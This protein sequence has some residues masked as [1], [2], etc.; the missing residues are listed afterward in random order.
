MQ[1]RIELRGRG[2]NPAQQYEFALQIQELI[3][4]GYVFADP[5]DLKNRTLLTGVRSPRAVLVLP[6][7]AKKAAKEPEAPKT[8]LDFDKLVAEAKE[9]GVPVGNV[10]DPVKLKAKIDKFKQG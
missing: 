10:K 8:P 6:E 9:L 5:K 1:D 7:K 4:K 2:R 3:Q